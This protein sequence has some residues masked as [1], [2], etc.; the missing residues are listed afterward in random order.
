MR[1]KQFKIIMLITVILFMLMSSINLE[2]YALTNNVPYVIDD[3]EEVNEYNS[4]KIDFLGKDLS[5]NGVHVLIH[6][7]ST[8]VD[9][10][11]TTRNTYFE[12]LRK[13]KNGEQLLVLTYYEDIN[14]I[15][16]YQDAN[17]LI[18]DSTISGINKD[19][20]AYKKHDDINNGLLYAYSIVTEEISENYD[21]DVDLSYAQRDSIY[22][23]ETFKSMHLIFG[24][25]IILVILY[26]IIGNMISP[27]KNK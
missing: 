3:L 20:E 23:V 6:S 12:W 25:L 16:Y 5:K 4:D 26:S 27:N 10:L 24:S 1:T 14:E 17:N 7:K 15:K 18:S 2:I 8:A 13:L 19:L 9:Y 22:K 11:K 21:L